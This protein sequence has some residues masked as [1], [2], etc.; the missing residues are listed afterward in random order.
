[1]IDL[2][3]PDISFKTERQVEAYS[4]FFLSL[5]PIDAASEFQTEEEINDFNLRRERF[6]KTQLN[7]LRGVDTSKANSNRIEG[8]YFKVVNA[9][10]KPLSSEG[11]AKAS[12][13]FNYR[14]NPF[15]RNRAIYFGKTKRCCEIEKFHLEYQREVLRNHFKPNHNEESEQV[16]F[17]KHLVK[18]Y[19]VKIDNILVLTSKPSWD[20]IGITQGA[21]MNEWYDLNED[22]EIPTSS[23]ILG[24]I[25]RAHG[26]NGILYKSIRHQIDSNL[27]I[28]EENTGALKFKELDSMSYVPSPELIMQE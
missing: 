19:E 22:Y 6:L 4:K 23:Q 3:S 8:Q 11:A 12:S 5:N 28:F 14:D 15:L 21:F 10:H 13:R 1:M 9:S 2:N 25:A 18:Q 7:Y 20:A 24:T 16:L 26:F 17:P 27:V